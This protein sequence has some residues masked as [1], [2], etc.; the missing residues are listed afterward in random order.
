MTQDDSKQWMHLLSQKNDPTL[1]KACTCEPTLNLVEIS[2]D[3][4]DL[5]YNRYGPSRQKR[6]SGRTEAHEHIY[7]AMTT[8][9]SNHI[10][11]SRAASLDVFP[12]TQMLFQRSRLRC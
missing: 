4:G 10:Y 9:G 12:I 3:L 8:V 5:A 11:Y 6:H 1:V 2:Y 7:Y